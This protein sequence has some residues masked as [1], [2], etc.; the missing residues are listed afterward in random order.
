MWEIEIILVYIHF[1]RINR[2]PF[3]LK[4]ETILASQDEC[5]GN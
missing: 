5:P 2:I 1:D 4:K 3:F